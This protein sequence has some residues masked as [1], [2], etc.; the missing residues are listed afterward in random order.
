[1]LLCQ[2]LVAFRGRQACIPA[3]HHN[4]EGHT[5][6]LLLNQH[7]KLHAAEL[8]IALHFKAKQA[9]EGGDFVGKA[10]LRRLT[11]ATSSGKVDFMLSKHQFLCPRKSVPRQIQRLDQL[12]E[13]QLEIVTVA[14]VNVEKATKGW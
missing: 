7:L 6:K 2:D 11:Q 3:F 5:A 8:H 12:A 1:M 10:L 14:E 9:V 4:L 13:A